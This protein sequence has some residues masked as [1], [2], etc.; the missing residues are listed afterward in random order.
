M[1]TNPVTTARAKHIDIKMHFV[2]ECINGGMVTM[3]HEMS[4]NQ[5]ADVLTKALPS[6]S[7]KRFREILVS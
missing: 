2:R 7:F 3:V 1:S 4:A 5:V 6:A